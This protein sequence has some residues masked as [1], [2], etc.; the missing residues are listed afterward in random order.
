MLKEM[1]HNATAP[2][3]KPVYTTAMLNLFIQT[4]NQLLREWIIFIYCP[5][6]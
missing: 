5:S 2:S 4:Q 6:S 1:Q 3:Q